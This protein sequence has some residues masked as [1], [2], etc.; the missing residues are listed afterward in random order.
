M[1]NIALAFAI[2]AFATAAAATPAKPKCS[3]ICPPTTEQVEQIDPTVPEEAEPMWI[4]EFDLE[5]I[6]AT[7]D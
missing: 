3:G 5:P 6:P 7:A 4:E 2:A 1:K